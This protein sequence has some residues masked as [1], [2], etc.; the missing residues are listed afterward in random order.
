MFQIVKLKY[1]KPDVDPII[2]PKIEFCIMKN[3]HLILRRQIRLILQVRRFLL[4]FVSKGKQPVQS[5]RGNFDLD[6]ESESMVSL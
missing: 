2:L 5:I 3:Y 6:S 1:T 4:S